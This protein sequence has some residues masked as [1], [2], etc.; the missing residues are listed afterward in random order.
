MTPDNCPHCGADLA[1]G[2][3]A[4]PECGSCEKTG[5]S[6]EAAASGLGIPDQ[7]FDYD[8]F[9]QREF[10]EAAKVV[11]RGVS[12]LWWVVAVVILILVVLGFVF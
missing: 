2:A 11:P 10:G 6:E 1:R 12:P 4:C 3:K 7:E 9:T 5:W 8:D